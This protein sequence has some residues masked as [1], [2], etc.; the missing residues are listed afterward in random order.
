MNFKWNVSVVTDCIQLA[1]VWQ[2]AFW[3]QI[4]QHRFHSG[5]CVIPN[6]LY[7]FLHCTQ[8]CVNTHPNNIMFESSDVAAIISTV[9]KHQ[10]NQ[11][12]TGMK[13]FGQYVSTALWLSIT[14]KWTKIALKSICHSQHVNKWEVH[15]ESLCLRRQQKMSFLR[16]IRVSGANQKLI[17]LY[18]QPV[19]QR[20][21]LGK[22]DGMVH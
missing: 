13:V 22:G 16:R 5:L 19:K 17:N 15:I 3:P 10:T 6:T 1:N 18:Y 20:F 8:T 12:T 11:Y 9:H 4:S 2:C 7:S 14:Q 21:W